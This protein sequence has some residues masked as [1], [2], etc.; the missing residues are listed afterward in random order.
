MLLQTRGRMTAQDLAGELEVSERTIYRDVN[1]LSFSGVPVYAECGPGG[2]ISL[3]ESYQS[4]LTGLTRDEVR[5]LF[6]VSIPPALTELGLDHELRAAMLK[7]SAALPSTLRGDEQRTRQRIYIDPNIWDKERS[8]T[9]A[10][11]LQTVQQAVWNLSA[12][13]IKYHS[14]LGPNVGLLETRLDPYGVVAKAGEWYVIARREDYL[15]VLKITRIEQAKIIDESFQIPDDFDLVRF[16]QGWCRDVEQVQYSFPVKLR[17]A[18]SL[19]P[20]MSYFFGTRIIEIIQQTGEPDSIGWTT[21]E[22]SFESHEDARS[23]LLR[24]GGVVEVLE[25]IALRYSL[26]DYAEQILAVYSDGK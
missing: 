11:H 8:F 4:D 7:L 6:M 9:P 19:I 17:V 1:A 25:P 21:L 5:A 10:A 13:E 24:F 20:K 22:I 15:T 23:R 26:K 3:I 12:L 16:W 18:P 2:G 14:V